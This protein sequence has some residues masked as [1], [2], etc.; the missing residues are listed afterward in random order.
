MRLTNT[1]LF[2]A[3]LLCLV[4]VFPIAHLSEAG[5]KTSGTILVK[6]AL[7]TPGQPAV[8]E[9]RLNDRGLLTDAALGGEPLDLLVDGAVA[10]TG[11]TGGDGRAFLRYQ[12][13]VQGVIPIHVRVGEHSRISTEEASA[14]LAV[15]EQRN[16]IVVIEITSLM[17]SSSAK[18]PFPGLLLNAKPQQKP[19]PDAADELAKLTQFYYRVIYVVSLPSSDTDQFRANVEARNWLKTHHFPSGYIL[20]LRSGEDVLGA[21]LDELHH[22]GWK[23]VKTGVG[24]SKAFIEAFLKRR[25]DAIMLLEP[26]TDDVP[27]RAKVAKDWKDIRKKL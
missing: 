18:R 9:A 23:T 11:M 13:K 26:T 14:N 24:R 2:R 27:K 1:L 16:P 25:L 5:N 8:I 22:A 6:D 3:V 17:D 12:T 7:T 20:V 10:G 15:W 21:K 4:A 19:F